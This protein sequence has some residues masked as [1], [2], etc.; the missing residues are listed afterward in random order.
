[1]SIVILDTDHFSLFQRRDPRVGQRVA[2]IAPENLF[3]TIISAEEQ[4]RGRLN[5]IRRA[6]SAENAVLAYQRLNQLLTDLKNINI[7]DFTP[8]AGRIYEALV[9]QKIRIGTRDLRIAAIV[10][11]VQ[12]ILIT[13]NR[14]DFEKIPNLIWQDWTIQQV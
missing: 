5:V 14:R 9:Q 13:R 2:M 1:M 8:D 7:L 11:S 12:G 10:I 6:S 4:I 3:I